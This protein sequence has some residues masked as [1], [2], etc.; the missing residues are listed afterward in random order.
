MDGLSLYSLCVLGSLGLYLILRTGG[1]VVRGAGAIVGIAAFIGL[2]FQVART[3]GIDVDSAPGVFYIVLSLLAVISAVKLISHDRPVYSALYFVLVVLASAGLFLLLEAEFMAFALVIVYAGAILITYM[4]VIMLAQ[5]APDPSDPDA[6][7][8]YDRNPR[9]PLAGA[10]V[11]FIMLAM[12]SYMVSG[13]LRE[14]A[15]QPSLPDA[16]TVAW[17]DLAMMP[18]QLKAIIAD[19]RPEDELADDQEPRLVKIGDRTTALVHYT[20]ADGSDAEPLVLTEDHLPENIQR[21]GL[22]LI[23]EFKG[24]QLELAGVILLMAMFGAVVLARKQIELSEDEKRQAAGMKRLGH[25][26]DPDDIMPEEGRS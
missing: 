25:E 1:R 6:Q 13:T 15:P 5:Q 2:V 19:E 3:A 22:S 20:L 7:P 26:D 4:F 12:L 18:E 23:L 10:S 16:R 14:P 21:V 8:E 9:E 24:G 17:D 11:G